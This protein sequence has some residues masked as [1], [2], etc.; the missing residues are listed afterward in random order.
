[1]HMGWTAT[2]GTYNWADKGAQTV[3]G[4]ASGIIAGTMVATPMGWRP[5]EAVVAGDE[6]M[7]FDGGL[8]RVTAVSRSVLSLNAEETPRHLW[9]LHVPA[10]LLGNR[11]DMRLM[12]EE[13]IVL[14]SDAAEEAWGDPFALIPAQAL[15][16]LPGVERIK[17]QGM[18]E[19]VQLA[20]EEDQVIFVEGSALVFCPSTVMGE[21]VTLAQMFDQAD[22]ATP[23]YQV[24]SM[25]DARLLT[26]CFVA[27]MSSTT[28]TFDAAVA[29]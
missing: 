26:T 19:I 21:P 18:I 24:L 27:Q 29:A 17:P 10:G 11:R 2:G 6:V 5:V 7:T 22:E 3:P 9:P 1:M 12:P 13:T 25:D 4:S 23:A 16:E 8:Q 15:Q 20:F 14:E 28:D